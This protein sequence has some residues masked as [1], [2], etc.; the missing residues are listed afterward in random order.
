MRIRSI[1]P[2]FWTSESVGRLSRDARLLFIGLWSF[3]DDSGRGRGAFPA[4]SGTLF[5]YDSDASK[6]LPR[7]FAELEAEGMVRRYKATDGN[8]YYDL[9]NWLKHQKIEKPSKS[10][11]PVFTEDSP[12]TPRILPD[13]SGE[14]QGAGSREQGMGAGSGKDHVVASRL[15]D[16]LN[17]RTGSKFRPVETHLELLEQRLNEIGVNEEGIRAMIDR[18]VALWGSDP[19][20]SEFL[21]P[22]TLFG[23]TKFQGYYDQRDLPVPQINGHRRPES[24]QTQ[25]IIPLKMI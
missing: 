16:H 15:L 3:A 25:E 10:R 23:K 1:K 18:Q 13:I 19:K 24:N 7:W 14:E 4:I 20:M 21:R 11:I 5:P 17:S 6:S 9:P 2:E 12:N 8:T 22:Q